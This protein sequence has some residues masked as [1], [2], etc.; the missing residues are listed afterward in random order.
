MLPAIF[1]TRRQDS[2][3]VGMDRELV[4]VL[5]RHRDIPA[6]DSLIEAIN[7][8]ANDVP[9]NSMAIA[10]DS[11][12]FL[13]LPNHARSADI[14]DYLSSRHS[15]PLILP[16]QAIQEFWN[17]QLSSVDTVVTSLQKKFDKFR[18]EFSGI[19]PNFGDYS[20]KITELLGKFSEEHGHIYDEAVVRKTGKL[21]NVLRDKALVPYVCRQSFDSIAVQR[22]KTK[23]P[24]GFRDSGD[25][26]FYIWAD[27]LRGLQ[28]SKRNSIRFDKVALI[29]E[30][31]KPDW[32][33]AGMAHPVLSAEISALFGVPFE[34]WKLDKLAEMVVQVN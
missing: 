23:T 5:C 18:E 17:N 27:T 14:I 2:G 16:G 11:S 29:T 31:V 8:T 10:I 21:L 32:S 34:L 25:G 6:L 26:D 19:D 15:A 12:V 20:A 24:P 7:P 33:R 9:L 13:R 22:K 30:D 3:R 4:S 28:I 1:G